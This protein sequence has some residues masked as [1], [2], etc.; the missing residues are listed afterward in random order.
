MFRKGNC[1]T[2][3][4]FFSLVRSSYWRSAFPNICITFLYYFLLFSPCPHPACAKSSSSCYEHG[5]EHDEHFCR[6]AC[7]WRRGS[8]Y[9]LFLDGIFSGGILNCHIFCCRHII[10]TM[11]LLYRIDAVLIHNALADRFCDLSVFNTG[12][13][14]R[15]SNPFAVRSKRNADRCFSRKYA[16]VIN[17]E[18]G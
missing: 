18:V 2:A 9:R 7:L 1:Q 4:P 13:V 6:I 17:N 16:G 12:I 15:L 3:V 11:I 8:F 10:R 5:Y 14:K